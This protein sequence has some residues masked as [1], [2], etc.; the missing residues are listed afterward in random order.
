MSIG[1][2]TDEV[3]DLNP[4]IIERYKIKIVPYK[5]IWPEGENISGD[6]VYQ[7][8]IKADQHG[9]EGL[10]KTSQASPKEF[11]NAYG[12]QFKNFKEILCIPLSST[13]SGGY[14]SAI[15][16][17]QMIEDPSKVYVL[18]SCQISAGQ[19][20]LVLR[21]IELI[22][23]QREMREVITELKKT[24][25][26]IYVYGFLADSKWAER[27]G[28]VTP[29]QANW[30]RRLQKF[31]MRPLMGLKDGQVQK[32]GFRLGVKEIHEALFKEIETKSRKIRKKGKI[33]VV[34][35]HCDNIEE[36]RKLKDKLKEIQAEVSFI[37]LADPVIGVHVGPGSL[38]A[39]WTKIL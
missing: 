3:A 4:K 14:N 20:L 24:I 28:R 35:T 26:F 30:M 11:A 12:E 37:N 1:I 34:I 15:Q 25:P 31:G 16:G 9:L 32:I 21:A 17:K 23:E 38:I 8:M 36:A 10:P 39:A 5:I 7:K 18:D 19:A 22:Q 33:R 29:S 2:V 27:G 13:L 6:N